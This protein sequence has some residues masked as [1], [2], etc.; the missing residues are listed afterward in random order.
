MLINV[1]GMGVALACCIIAYLN[2]SYNKN[3]DAQHENA[4]KIY[5]VNFIRDFKGAITENGIT[6]MPIGNLI[7]DKI[8]G[9]EKSIR[10]TPSG[11]NFR[12]KDDLFNTRIY[13]VDN[14]FL[15]LFTF[16]LKSGSTSEFENKS[17]IYI[18]SQLAVKYFGQE[19]A[20]GQ[21]MTHVLDSGT[22]EYIVA[23]IFEKMPSNSSMQFD[24]VTD[25]DNFLEVN[26]VDEN[27]WKD[28][29]TLFLEVRDESQIPFIEKELQQY[30]ERQNKAKPDYAVSRFYLDP[31]PGMAVRAERD[32][33]YNHW[34][35]SGLPIAAAIAPNVMAILV[36]LIAVFNFTNTSIAMASRRLK[37]IGIRKV[38]GSRKKQ[39]IIQ[40]ITENM[41][42]CFLAGI[43]A[44][45]IAELL[46][47]AYN[48]MWNFLELDLNYLSNLGFLG[49]MFVLL[50][51]TGLLAGSYPAFYVSSFEPTSILKGTFKFGGTNW[52]TKVLLGGQ[53]LIT[54]LALIFAVGFIQNANYQQNFDLGFSVDNVVS[55]RVNGEKEFDALRNALVKNP[56]IT[57]V[58]G[59]RHHIMSSGW[60][61]PIKYEDLEK[62]VDIFDVGH[63]Y[64]DV[65]D[66]SLIEGRQ[67]KMDSETDIEESIIINRQLADEF[68]WEKD[69]IIGKRV[70]LRDTVQLYVV[71]VVEDIYTSALWDTTDPT[72]FRMSGKEGYA[73]LLVKAKNKDLRKVDKFIEAE[74]K[75][76]FPNRIYFSDFMDEA[77]AEA[78]LVNKNI[79]KLFTFLGV[80][81]TLL[82]A[83][84]LYT[85][86]SLN[87]IKR[88]K[89]I[90]VRKVLGASIQ[91]IVKKL[92]TQFAI[93]LLIAA[94]AASII[95]YLLLDLMMDSIWDY[96]Q[97]ANAI[98][99]LV[100]TLIVFVV[101]AITIGYKVYS[102]AAMNPVN[103]L[104]DE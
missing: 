83:S 47:P 88:M 75:K 60:G 39:L 67:F 58:A 56:D 86:V 5:R 48:E 31:L 11:G 8:S 18:S 16:P 103:T 33:V 15:D 37:E 66:I 41:I 42:L 89:E 93:I 24:A 44:L 19:D 81:A 50:I 57:L 94:V 100:G 63:D 101:A 43:V 2:Y 78:T 84:G 32:N 36:L 53:F 65:M 76:I 51:I 1:L 27:N 55:T 34:F 38:M 12:I 49:F 22:R 102:A 71:G 98:T 72:M 73:R 40:F 17:N 26:E 82:S 74:W 87:I 91:N 64:F 97:K 46:V 80:I 92:N 3:Y 29:T 14:G 52:V 10:V 25:F 77:M 59:T 9:V 61:D 30:K 35:R 62:E 28:W 69:E 70:V 85:M 13:Y 45:L 4:E 95:S 79:V 90:G 99:F 96:Y 21:Q 104:R 68:G 20:L 54:I 23:G 6:P 7:R